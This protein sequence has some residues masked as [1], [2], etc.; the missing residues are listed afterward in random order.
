[1]SPGLLSKD[2]FQVL[3]LF[4]KRLSGIHFFCKLS[5]ERLSFAV[6]NHF[7]LQLK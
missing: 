1:M 3:V 7:M 4:I 5:S 6:V 2:F